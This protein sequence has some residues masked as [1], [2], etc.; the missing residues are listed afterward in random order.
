MHSTDSSSHFLA[1]PPP[2][3]RYPSKPMK[4]L[5]NRLLELFTTEIYPVLATHDPEY[6]RSLAAIGIWSNVR[7]VPP[8]K[9]EAFAKEMKLRAWLAAQAI[10]QANSLEPGSVRAKLLEGHETFYR[11][12]SK[13]SKAPTGV[14]WFS[15]RVAARCRQEAPK[16][17]LTPL[18]WLREMLAVCFNWSSFDQLESFELQKHERLPAILGIGKPMPHYKVDTRRGTVTLP[19]DYWKRQ[20]QILLGGERQIVLPWVP[21]GR[22][23]KISSL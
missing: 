3:R 1:R 16:A 12:A 18:D 15:E 17:G 11:V 6:R 20:G 5:E 2:L 14:W 21:A 7:S 10:V 8:Q 13:G 19:P 23:K 4:D 22:V 9:A